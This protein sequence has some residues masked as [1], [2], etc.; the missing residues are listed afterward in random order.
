MCSCRF[1]VVSRCSILTPAGLQVSLA[2]PDVPQWDRLRGAIENDFLE[3]PGSLFLN[4]PR[5]YSIDF[6]ILKPL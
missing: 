6:Y 1:V 5:P 3:V 2:K 4:I